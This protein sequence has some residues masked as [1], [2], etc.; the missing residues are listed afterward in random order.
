MDSV[1]IVAVKDV[2]KTYGGAQA[3]R[4]VSLSIKPGEIHALI[5]ENGAGKSTLIKILTGVVVPDPGG[6]VLVNGEVHADWTPIH[7]IRSGVAA[8][9]QDFSLFPNLSVTENVCF[10]LS[11]ERKTP[12]VNWR[13]MRSI[14]GAALNRLGVPIPLDARL[15]E[16]SIAKQQL[17]AIARAFAFEA[18]LIIMDEP[19]SALG[20]SDVEI[21]FKIMR[22]LRDEGI[23][24]LFVSHKIDELYEIAETFTILRDGAGMG[25]YP[26]KDLSTDELISLMVGREI[27][28]VVYPKERK[29]E[30]LLEVQGLTK[31]GNYADICFELCRGEVLG[32]TG[33]VGSGRSE[34]M[35]SLCGVESPDSGSI[36]I[37]GNP[38]RMASPAA[39]AALGISYVPE[40]RLSE[41][42]VLKKS[43]A[44]NLLVA[45]RSKIEKRF[46]L[47]DTE[48][49]HNLVHYWINRLN[50]KP[51]EPEM[52]TRSLSGG[53]QQKVVVAKCLAGEPRILMVDEPTNG[54]DIGA[55]TELHK[56]IRNLASNGLAVLLISSELPEVLAVADRIIVMRRGRITGVFDAESA[57]QE[58]LMHAALLSTS[59]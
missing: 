6:S 35:Q 38:V 3:L 42:L 59:A 47:R 17:V 50:V 19:T 41:G 14:A 26:A 57:T 46:G 7:A 54:I 30:P 58:S 36:K 10:G 2:S 20:Q 34:L 32:I 11:R 23:S 56:L 55:K 43:V 16:L 49:E 15:G 18:R 22:A 40:D 33:L 51:P 27:E 13:E 29:S 25:T 21:L 9:Y 24:F 44:E 53:N 5:G 28:Y 31:R 12:V 37:D 52:V 1:P 4:N 39:A 45:N 48:A 8:I